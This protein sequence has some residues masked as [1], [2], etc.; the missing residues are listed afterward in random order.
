[1]FSKLICW[2]FKRSNYYQNESTHA[3]S[4]TAWYGFSI[5]LC[6]MLYGFANVIEKA[7]FCNENFA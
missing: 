1:M 2:H 7:E 3:N 4:L 5:K 6:D